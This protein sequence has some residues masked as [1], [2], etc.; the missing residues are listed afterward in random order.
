MIRRL[1]RLPRRIDRYVARHV[2]LAT[3]GVWAVLLGFDVILD[4]AGELKD[5]GKQDYTLSHA[6]MYEIFTLPRR[7]YTLFPTVAVIGSLLGLGGLAARS[8]LTAMRAAGVSRMQIGLGALLPLA[9]ITAVMALNIETIAPAGEQHAQMLTNAKSGQLIMARYSG[10]WAREG[11]LFLN[12]RAGGPRTVGDETWLEL[13]DVR[14]YQF[15][16]DGRLR[17]LAQARTADHRG[18]KWTL[19]DVERAH[20]LPRSVVMDKV[21]AE[22]W[23]TALDEQSLVATL[24]KPRYLSSRE[25]SANIEYLRRNKL[26]A[27][28]FVSTY[29]ARWFY[30][31]QVIVLVL[32]TFPFAFASLRSGGLGKRLF[33]GIIIGVGYMLSEQMLVNLSEVFHFDVRLAYV[34]T[35]MALLAI[36]WGW[37]GRRL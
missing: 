2:L 24:A 14:L 7:L 29:W 4:F 26:D 36:C 23:H 33:T 20:F 18:G 34:L 16:G 30:P 32:A 31:V 17:S 28:S 19:H 9:L 35:P 6:V 25:L 37:I 27:G 21:P 22:Q 1:P 8:E 11:Q 15:D 13:Q 3:L 12:A 5:V 10:L